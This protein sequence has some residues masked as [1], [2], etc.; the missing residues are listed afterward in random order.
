MPFAR[1]SWFDGERFVDLEDARRSARQWCIEVARREHGTTRRVVQEHFE[2]VEKAKLRP[3]PTHAFDVPRWT[4]A[5]VR[6]DHHVQ[7]SKA[8][9]SVPTRYIGRTLRVREDSVLVRLYVGGQLIKTH[10]RQRPGH[11]STDVHDYPP[12]KHAYATRSVERL[13]AQGYT[14]GPSVGVYLDRLFDGPLPWSRM[15]QGYQ[16]VRLCDR[17]GSERVDAACQHALSFDVVDVPRVAKLLK[18]DF[19]RELRAEEQGALAQLSKHP[20]FGRERDAFRT[21]SSDQGDE[22]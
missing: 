15:R 8:L 19:E 13:V 12:G 1:E 14:K 5:K 17:Y 18:R 21:R 10:P 6:P 16:L 3:P 11:R 4:S 22:R 2:Q 9:Y 20:R 7:V